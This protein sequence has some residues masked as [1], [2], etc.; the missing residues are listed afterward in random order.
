M[1][2]QALFYL[3]SLPIFELFIAFFAGIFTKLADNTHK[4]IYGII[5]GIL[6]AINI[7]F[8]PFSSLFVG[9]ILA[10]VLAGKIDNKAHYLGLIALLPIFFIDINL[11]ELALFLIFAY[12][13]ELFE[14]YKE[15]IRPFLPLSSLFYSLYS[16]NPYYFLGLISFDIGYNIVSYL[17]KRFPNFS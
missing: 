14:R 13:D 12:L 17:F 6:L 2:T 3:L 11:F 4:L 15:G 5:Y 16:S 8:A 7:S 10:E 1:E 9:T